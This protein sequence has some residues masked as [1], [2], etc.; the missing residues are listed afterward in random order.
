MYFG[1]CIHAGLA[2]FYK[3]GDPVAAYIAETKKNNWQKPKTYNEEKYL[4]VGIDLLERYKKDGVYL[5]PIPEWIEQRKIIQLAN[6]KTGNIIPIP[7]SFQIDLITKDG[8][9]VDH[10]T[11]SSADTNQNE[12]NRLQGIAYQMAYRAIFGKKPKGF[13]QNL[14][15]KQ[16]VPKFIPK[17]LSYSDDDEVYAFDLIEH[18]LDR[19]ERKGYLIDKPTIKTFYPCPVK[20]IC[21]I[22]SKT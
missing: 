4:S 2:S 21:R 12:T 17:I 22:H 16:K 6:P 20:T 15:V 1:T 19:I 8:Y 7:F 9:I 10:K 3:G 11:S 5:E 14:I 18:V 13:I